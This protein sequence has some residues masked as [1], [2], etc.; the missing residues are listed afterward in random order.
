MGFQFGVG[1]VGAGVI[2]NVHAEALT[3]VQNAQLLAIAEPREDAGQQMATKYAATWYGSYLEMLAHPGIDL[4]ILGTPSGLHPEQAIIAAQHGKHVITEKPMA[5]TS[6]GATRMIESCERASVQLAVIFQ[7]RL[8]KDV[9]KV[10]RAIEAGL[11]GKPLLAQGYLHWHRTQAYYD[12]NGGWRGTWALD[13]GGALMNQ[14]IHTIDQ[15]QWLMGGASSVQAMIAT[16]T[17]D[18]ETE[19]TAAAS[20]AFR[21]GGL[22]T[23]AATTSTDKD[24]PIHIEVVGEKGKAILESNALVSWEGVGEPTDDL[25]TPED[26]ELVEGWKVDEPFGGSH[27]RQLR[28]IF[29]ALER[30]TTPPFS[31]S[32]AR[33]AVDV[34]LGIYESART[35][36]R[37]EIRS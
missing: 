11:L 24:R 19:D 15:L 32:E 33:K 13:G 8:S 25:L 30:G 7:N 20:L 12:D 6:D 1:I 29:N 17:H 37:I 14:T 23:I 22:G 21:N 26:L 34:I 18:I 10:K 27:R 31:G 3:G 2:G 16:L 36:Q 28:A 35:G 5:I 4:V 9:F